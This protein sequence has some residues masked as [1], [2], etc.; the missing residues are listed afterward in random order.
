MIPEEAPAIAAGAFF[1]LRDPTH[2]LCTIISGRSWRPI[3][4]VGWLLYCAYV[5]NPTFERGGNRSKS[6]N[7]E[8]EVSLAMA[9]SK[10]R[11]LMGIEFDRIGLGFRYGDNVRGIRVVTKFPF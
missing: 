2:L 5:D 10:P 9:F 7:G 6:S 8:F 1:C 3:A 11:K 4:S